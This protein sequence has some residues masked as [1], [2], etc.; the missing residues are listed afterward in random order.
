MGQFP[1]PILLSYFILFNRGVIIVSKC[2]AYRTPELKALEKCECNSGEEMQPRITKWI[3][4]EFAHQFTSPFNKNYQ[5]NLRQITLFHFNSQNASKIVTS[6][7]HF[8][9]SSTLF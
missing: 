7:F 5:K 8:S 3:L 9:P 4:K 6:S 1:Q 2:E